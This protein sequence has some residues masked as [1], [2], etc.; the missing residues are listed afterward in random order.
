MPHL[1]NL[2]DDHKNGWKIQLTVEISFASVIKNYDQPYT[3]HIH[4]QNLEVYI[5]YKTTKIIEDLFYSLLKEYQKSLKT[6]MKKSNLVF[7]SVDALY[8][9]LYK[10]SLAG[11]G[12]YMDSP[13]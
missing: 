3:I 1:S 9:S 13:E 11:G 4:S 10:I 6:K 5:G 2:I 7:E 12:S 8:Y